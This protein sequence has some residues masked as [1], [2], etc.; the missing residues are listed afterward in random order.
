MEVPRR[1]LVALIT[2]AIR[3][4][5]GNC[6]AIADN[7]YYPLRSE[8]VLRWYCSLSC[9]VPTLV[10]IEKVLQ[11]RP[12]ETNLICPKRIMAILLWWLFLC[13]SLS[14]SLSPFSL[15]IL[16]Y[17]QFYFRVTHFFLF[18]PLWFAFYGSVVSLQ[19]CFRRS[20]RPRRWLWH[21]FAFEATRH[22]FHLSKSND[23]VN[24]AY[25]VAGCLL[26]VALALAPATAPAPAPVL[27]LLRLL[28]P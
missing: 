17:A 20:R 8:L 9:A 27:A 2:R 7:L 18:A 23:V 26:A 5:S 25:S 12:I 15:Y 28:L 6:N 10:P 13:D 1:S 19:S 16:W 21:C 14:P 4:V 22:D 24:V 11:S 3:A